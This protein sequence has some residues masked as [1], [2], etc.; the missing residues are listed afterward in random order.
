[1]VR[2]KVH[3]TATVTCKVS[4]S[5]AGLVANTPKTGV[6]A[7]AS[8][9]APAINVFFINFCLPPIPLNKKR[10]NFILFY[11]SLIVYEPY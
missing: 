6:A 3:D 2:V 9:A 11:F 5:A 1:V 8:D 4:V 10:K 7:N